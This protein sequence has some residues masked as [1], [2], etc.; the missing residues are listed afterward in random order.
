MSIIISENQSPRSHSY[1][2]VEDDCCRSVGG[3]VCSHK[4]TDRRRNN[5]KR[6]NAKS[7]NVVIMSKGNKERQR[8]DAQRSMSSTTIH[9]STVPSLQEFRNDE[10]LNPYSVL[11]IRKD[12]TKTEIRQAYRRHALL[13][14]PGR[15]GT[16]SE[17]GKIEQ[18][19]R[20]RVFTILAA[21]CETL[22]ERE[23]RARLDTILKGPLNKGSKTAAPTNAT[24]EKRRHASTGIPFLDLSKTYSVSESDTTDDGDEADNTRACNWWPW[25]AS[26][27]TQQVP[28]TSHN[29]NDGRQRRQQLQTKSSSSTDTPDNIH[30]TK[31]E[32]D[33]LFGGPLSLMYQARMFR[34]FSDPTKIFDQ[35]F[36]HNIFPSTNNKDDLK[37]CHTTPHCATPVRNHTQT[38]PTDYS[39]LPA[40]GT[41]NLPATSTLPTNP[42]SSSSW[43]GTTCE[44]LPDGTS[45][46]I[47]YRILHGRTLTKRETIAVDPVTGKKKST[48]TVTSRD[49]P[50][51]NTERDDTGAKKRPSSA[52]AKK[53]ENSEADFVD[54]IGYWDCCWPKVDFTTT[55]D[56]FG[57]QSE[58]FGFDSGVIE[59]NQANRHADDANPV[60]QQ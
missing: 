1:S 50:Y 27:D 46:Y 60:M 32:T 28:P 12:S 3:S 21:C 7:G 14:H 2:C 55:Q 31:T 24:I 35:V 38:T 52:N 10:V 45:V 17:L 53:R 43:T 54:C 22:L 57:L 23:S 18:E 19:R 51:D 42:K 47:T 11:R 40:V 59:E 26:S 15:K 9:A 30:Y 25:S 29:H 49:L 37:N 8:K 13:H 20:E 6:G 34:P 33:R 5:E 39:H 56:Y 36:G 4:S 41:T 48:I 58:N 44:T 16:G